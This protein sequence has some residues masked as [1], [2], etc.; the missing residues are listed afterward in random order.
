[1]NP[2]YWGDTILAVARKTSGVRNRFPE[3]L[4]SKYVI[5]HQSK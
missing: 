3:W 1:M 5:E 4:Y 2:T